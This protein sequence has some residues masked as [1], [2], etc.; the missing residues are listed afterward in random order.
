MNLFSRQIAFILSS[1]T[2]IGL[3]FSWSIANALEGNSGQNVSTILQPKRNIEHVTS[4]WKGHRIFAEWLVKTIKPMQIVDLGVDFGY[5]T[6]VFANAARENGF[7]IVTGID[8]FEG[9]GQ[10]GHRTTHASVLDWIDALGLTNIEIIKGD[11]KEVSLTWSR[12]IDILHI[13]GYH[14]YE[15]VHSDFTSWEKFVRDDGI[16]LFHDINVPHPGFEV[17]KFFRELKGGHKLYCSPMVSAFI[18]K[19]K[20]CINQ[21]SMHFQTF[22]ILIRRHF[23]ELQKP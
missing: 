9:D 14:S 18:Q 11:F 17:I 23:N 21:S 1:M 7:G 12:Q 15:A 13:D 5:S 2:S 10:T 22:M 20:R 19:V 4:A 6:L 8:L 3:I 16:V